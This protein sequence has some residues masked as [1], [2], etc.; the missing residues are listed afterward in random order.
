MVSVPITVITGQNWPQTN[1]HDYVSIKLYLQEQVAGQVWLTGHGLPAPGVEAQV[2]Q[3]QSFYNFLAFPHV[4]KV[5]ATAPVITMFQA[6]RKRKAQGQK[7]V[8]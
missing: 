7:S 6:G 8:C 2:S 1:E 3:G 4:P 5:A